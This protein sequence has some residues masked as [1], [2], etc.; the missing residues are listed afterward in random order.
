MIDDTKTRAALVQGAKDFLTG[1]ASINTTAG[2]VE[3]LPTI[4]GDSIAW[5]N[6]LLNTQGKSIWSS[7]FYRPNIP[8][9]RSIGPG[10]IDETSGFLQIDFNIGE[11]QGE[12]ELIAWENKARL[13]FHHGRFFSYGGH[14]VIVTSAGMGQGRHVGND[15][16]K[17]L[18]IS[19]RSQT[20][21][22]Q[23]L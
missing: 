3:G 7:V 2:L 5:E 11:G 14:S 9:T 22:P 16:R 8:A 21:R 19:F 10:G 4:S 23:L 17:S 20:K 12:N 18:T 6:R 13:F 15:F 1:N